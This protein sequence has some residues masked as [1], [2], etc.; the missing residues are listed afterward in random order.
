MREDGINSLKEEDVLK[1]IFHVKLE[2]PS[3]DYVPLEDKEDTPLTTKI[4]W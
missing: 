4:H 3:E 1:W 2:N